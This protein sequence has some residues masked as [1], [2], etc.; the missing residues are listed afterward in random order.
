M[1]SSGW[2]CATWE[3]F[4]PAWLQLSIFPFLPC[5]SQLVESFPRLLAY[6]RQVSRHRSLKFFQPSGMKQCRADCINQRCVFPSQLWSQV[7]HSLTSG[8]RWLLT[9]ITDTAGHHHLT[10]NSQLGP[11]ESQPNKKQAIPANIF[12]Q[13]QPGEIHQ[14]HWA[15][16]QSLRAINVSPLE[17]SWPAGH[18]SISLIVVYTEALIASGLPKGLIWFKLRSFFFSYFR[19]SEITHYGLKISLKLS[20][21]EH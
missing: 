19:V 2:D 7:S 1:G 11:A 8:S 13:F 15:E 16:L 10:P 5:H 4:C 3:S 14:F 18:Q 6:V 17:V 21:W 9:V 20:L 12:C